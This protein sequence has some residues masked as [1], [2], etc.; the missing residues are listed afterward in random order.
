MQFLGPGVSPEHS[1]RHTLLT[2]LIYE[3]N[4]QGPTKKEEKGAEKQDVAG[5]CVKNDGNCRR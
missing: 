3:I 2:Q 4:C 1:R 5:N